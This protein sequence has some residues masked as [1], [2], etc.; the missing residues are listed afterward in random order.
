MPT[1]HAVI[2]KEF[3]FRGK[4]ERFSNGYNF[5]YGGTVS[6]ATMKT[7]C[8]ALVAMERT[9]HTTTI[10]FPYRVAGLLGEDAVYSEEV[11][12]PPSGTNPN[13]RA[14]HPEECYLAE[15]KFGPK[16]YMRKYYHCGLGRN[17]NL[18][19]D[20]PVGQ[21]VTDINAALAKL[22]DGTL[23]GGATYCRPNGALAT[24][25]FTVDPFLRVHQLKRRGKRP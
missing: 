15:S 14:S 16:R 5:Q 17:G 6:A 18:T 10:K 7:L 3:T 11:A 9:F 22:T 8:D 12:S 25:P 24:A 13:G 4:P 19:D 2:T 20:T 1:V 21:A 23:P